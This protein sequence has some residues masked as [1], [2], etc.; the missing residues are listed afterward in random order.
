VQ[1]QRLNELL[2]KLTLP[3]ATVHDFD[4]LPTR[5]RAIATD[6]ESGERVVISSGD[7]T[8][9]MRASLSVP[10]VFVP[11][12]RE[13]R[14]LVDG[15]LADNLPVDVARAMGVDVLIV[16]DAGFPLLGRDQLTTV[17]II[18]NQMIAI[19]VRRNSE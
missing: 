3:V 1:G 5:F 13:G 18:T 9:A 6:L 16:V 15:G 11:V 14:L 19:L 2:R 8:T 10:G 7:L 12:E 17:P 4:A